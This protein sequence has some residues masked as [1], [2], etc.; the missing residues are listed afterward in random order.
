MEWVVGEF[1]FTHFLEI[2][3]GIV[4]VQSSVNMRKALCPVILGGRHG[5]D[6]VLVSAK[7][8]SP[9]LS[10]LVICATSEILVNHRITASIRS[11]AVISKM[12][13]K[14]SLDDGDAR[15]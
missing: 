15:S 12:P 4:I 5:I 11:T 14:V 8:E 3:D 10:F 7:K 1:H 9:M 2:F 13:V 6:I